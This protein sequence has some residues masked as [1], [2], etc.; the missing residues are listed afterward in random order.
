MGKE[1]LSVLIFDAG[2]W[3]LEGIANGVRNRS[4]EQKQGKHHIA[5]PKR[6]EKDVI[7]TDMVIRS[8]FPPSGERV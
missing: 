7:Q 6:F 3:A 4:T 2:R 5:L 1:F 8:H